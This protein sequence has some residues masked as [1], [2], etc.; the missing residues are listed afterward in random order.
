[1]LLKCSFLNW[2]TITY[3]CHRNTGSKYVLLINLCIV[4][5][6]RYL[7]SIY[8]KYTVCISFYHI[9]INGLPK[10]A[11]LSCYLIFFVLLVSDYYLLRMGFPSNCFPGF[12]SE[13]LS[14]IN[15]RNTCATLAINRTFRLALESQTTHADKLWTIRRI[16]KQS[17]LIS[18][19]Q[20]R[21]TPSFWLL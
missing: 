7:M 18:R 13:S 8:C 5:H 17:F 6:H 19:H 12:L 21:G 10:V 15:W 3:S 4:I 16:M 14:E 11:F 2:V 9:K 1:M 20:R